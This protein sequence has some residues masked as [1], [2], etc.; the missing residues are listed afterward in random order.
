[1]ADMPQPVTFFDGANHFRIDHQAIN[2]IAGNLYNLN[3]LS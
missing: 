1:M 2:F 3:V